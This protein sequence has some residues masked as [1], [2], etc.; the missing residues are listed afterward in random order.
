MPDFTGPFF[1]YWLTRGAIALILVCLVFA[2]LYW[3]ENYMNAQRS[4]EARKRDEDRLE[5]ERRSQALRIVNDL[6]PLSQ[7]AARLK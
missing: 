7:R 1:G 4:D 3:I 2:A 5:Q 6:K